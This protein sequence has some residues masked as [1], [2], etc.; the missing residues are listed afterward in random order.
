MVRRLPATEPWG[1]CLDLADNAEAFSVAVHRR[2][3]EGL[4]E[5]QRAARERLAAETWDE[6]ARLFERW[7]VGGV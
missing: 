5:A 4:P 7:A 3:E 2:I 1:D 6:K